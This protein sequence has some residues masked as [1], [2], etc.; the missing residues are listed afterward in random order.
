MPDI[1]V[2]KNRGYY[3]Q[4]AVIMVRITAGSRSEQMHRKIILK[5]SV[6]F[7][8]FVLVFSG[9][10]ESEQ[11]KRQ[12]LFQRAEWVVIPGAGHM[13]HYDQPGAVQQVLAD[14]LVS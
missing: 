7:L 13:L 14:F 10:S 3:Y 5:Y 6:F 2:K 11:A 4:N 12:G 9:C 8:L 1:V